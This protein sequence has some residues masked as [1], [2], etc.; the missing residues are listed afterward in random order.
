MVSASCGIWQDFRERRVTCAGVL[1]G[2][3]RYP[4][5]CR[6]WARSLQESHT[7]VLPSHGHQLPCSQVSGCSEPG[8]TLA[9]GLKVGRPLSCLP[10]KTL[11]PSARPLRVLFPQAMSGSQECAWCWVGGGNAGQGM[12]LEVEQDLWGNADQNHPK[13]AEGSGGSGTVDGRQPPV[14][15]AA[16]LEPPPDPAVLAAGSAGRRTARGLLETCAE[17]PQPLCSLWPRV[18]TAGC[19]VGE[20]V[21]PHPGAPLS[22]GKEGSPDTRYHVDRP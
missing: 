16:K 11:S 17:A 22:H 3:R 5:V 20:C 14:P 2:S 10:V 9:S 21:P 8:C 13:A 18:D 6:A 7:G 12:C 1:S 15:P 19:P 4:D